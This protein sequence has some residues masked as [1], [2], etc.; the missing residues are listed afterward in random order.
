MCNLRYN[1]KVIIRVMWTALLDRL[2]VLRSQTTNAT[3][4][5]RQHQQSISQHCNRWECHNNT[6]SAGEKSA[7]NFS[8]A[9]FVSSKHLWMP[10][11]YVGLISTTRKTLLDICRRPLNKSPTQKV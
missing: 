8:K 1:S 3:T 9:F 6:C 4:V 10:P 2:P 11:F 7:L 5:F